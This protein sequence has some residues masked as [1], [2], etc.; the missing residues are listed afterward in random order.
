MKSETRTRYNEVM[1]HWTDSFS[2]SGYGKSTTYELFEEKSYTVYT[3]SNAPPP[4]NGGKWFCWVPS[5]NL[6]D[7]WCLLTSCDI[8]RRDFAPRIFIV[9]SKFAKWLNASKRFRYLNFPQTYT[10]NLILLQTKRAFQ[11]LS[12]NFLTKKNYCKGSMDK[13]TSS[14]S[15]TSK[16]MTIPGRE[17]P[18]SQAHWIETALSQNWR[19]KR[20][21]IWK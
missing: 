20:W 1:F 2:E 9:I 6:W 19:K 21:T 15:K 8:L 11:C 17:E 5:K 16:S 14:S 4:M 13:C 10:P 18:T 3:Y 12:W 7:S